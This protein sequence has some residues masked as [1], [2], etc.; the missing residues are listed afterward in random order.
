[1]ERIWLPFAP[2]AV[3]ACAALAGDRRSASV[4]RSSRA[5]LALNVAAGVAWADL[6][7]SPW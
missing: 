2:W 6:F 1:V 7:R 3:L 4:A 5:W